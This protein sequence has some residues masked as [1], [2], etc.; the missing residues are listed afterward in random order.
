M[1]NQNGSTL[2]P[3]W[4]RVARG[5]RST[6][7]RSSLAQLTTWPHVGTGRVGALCVLART[8]SWRMDQRRHVRHEL[9]RK[10]VRVARGA[11]VATAQVRAVPLLGR[12]A[13]SAVG[14]TK[15]RLVH[16]R[17]G[18]DHVPVLLLGLQY[19]MLR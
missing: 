7:A 2:R 15:E 9:M 1:A 13:G 4:L 19:R 6:G 16:E 3:P 12:R 5:R 8:N 11:K 10:M 18:F 14:R 17:L